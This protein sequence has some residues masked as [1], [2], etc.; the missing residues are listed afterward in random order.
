[1][2]RYIKNKIRLLLHI[3]YENQLRGL[4]WAP[5]GGEALGPA[6]AGPPQCRGMSVWG[7]RKGWVVME[8]EYPHRRRG[9]GMG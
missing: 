8:W 2:Y 6:K 4:K 7:G 3:I 5:V 1:M 9:R